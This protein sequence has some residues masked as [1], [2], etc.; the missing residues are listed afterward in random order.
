MKGMNQAFISI[1]FLS[2]LS[3]SA[4]ESSSVV[5]LNICF[6]LKRKVLKRAYQVE[7]LPI[8][9][10]VS[11]L[12]VYIPPTVIF[13]IFVQWVS[14][15]EG[16]NKYNKERK[17]ERRRQTSVFCYRYFLKRKHSLLQSLEWVRLKNKWRRREPEQDHHPVRSKWRQPRFLSSCTFIT[18]FTDLV[19]ITS[20]LMVPPLSH[21]SSTKTAYMTIIIGQQEVT[22]E[23]NNPSGTAN[24][25]D[26]L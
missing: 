13:W 11:S 26:E 23:D 2:C 8:I 18:R 21:T 25:K 12:H 6:W 20:P 19:L 7:T 15:E 3:M 10:K 22:N 24:I 5:W 16:S 4:G 14:K 17:R 9:M 1:P